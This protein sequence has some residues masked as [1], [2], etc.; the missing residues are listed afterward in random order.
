MWETGQDPGGGGAALPP[1][2]EGTGAQAAL[3]PGGPLEEGEGDAE[4]TGRGGTWGSCR[5]NGKPSRGLKRWVGAGRGAAGPEVRRLQ[6]S[7]KTPE[8][9]PLASMQLLLRKEQFPLLQ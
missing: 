1:G 5:G 2:G 3:S 8:K 9:T 6:I 7:M 4:R